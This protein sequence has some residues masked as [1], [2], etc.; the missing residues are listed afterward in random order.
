MQYS[1][2]TLCCLL[3]AQQ[4][5][6]CLRCDRIVVVI[7][8]QFQTEAK[9]IESVFCG[10]GVLQTEPHYCTDYTLHQTVTQDYQSSLQ[11]I[12]VKRVL[13]YALEP[14]STMHNVIA[15]NDSVLQ[16]L[17]FRGRIFRN[18]QLPKLSFCA[19]T[20]SVT[21]VTASQ[22]YAYRNQFYDKRSFINKETLPHRQ[23]SFLLH[24][25]S[26]LR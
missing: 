19:A 16:E 24:A 25:R 3:S 9:Q 6:N 15:G 13:K 7:V 22:F 18:R 5:P 11:Y 23:E 20:R 2:L 10:R 1:R 21:T 26:G 8:F 12:I 17:S 14:C 4:Y